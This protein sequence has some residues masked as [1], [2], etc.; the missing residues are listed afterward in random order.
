[1]QIHKDFTNKTVH[2]SR[3]FNASLKT[4]WE[5]CTKSEILDQWWAPKPWKAE[6][7]SMNFKEGGFW[8]YAMAGPEGEKHWGKL[9][10]LEINPLKNFQAEDAFCDEN[11]NVNPELPV[12]KWNNVFTET[13]NG[14]RVEYFLQ[15]DKVEDLEKIIEMGFE[16]GVATASDGLE[17]LLATK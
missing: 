15:F 16:E 12:T 7:K 5:A 9:T 6:T 14:T 2:I 11:G 10:Y 1:M 13:E 3:E 17:E 8:L 4:V